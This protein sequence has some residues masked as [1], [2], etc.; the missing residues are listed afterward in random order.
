MIKKFM[1]GFHKL[2][3]KSILKYV[4]KCV[5]FDD[6]GDGLEVVDNKLQVVYIISNRFIYLTHVKHKH[7]ALY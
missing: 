6:I 2:T 1:L 7:M 4:K 3:S 5:T